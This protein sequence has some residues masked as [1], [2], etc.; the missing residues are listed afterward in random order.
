MGRGMVDVDRFEIIETQG[1]QSAATA[2]PPLRSGEGDHA[3]HGGGG[4]SALH[5]TIARM[6]YFLSSEIPP[7]LADHSSGALR[8]ASTSARVSGGKRCSFLHT[9]STSHQVAR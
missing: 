6:P 4:A 2:Y 5:P 7:F 8:K 9:A 3:K 1:A